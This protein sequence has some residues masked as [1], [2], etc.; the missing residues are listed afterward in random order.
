MYGD[1]KTE[2]ISLPKAVSSSFLLANTYQKQAKKTAI[3]PEQ[4][5]LAYTIL[6]LTN[7]AGEVAGKYKKFLRDGTQFIDLR[8]KLI[9]ELGDVLWYAAMLSEEIGTTLGEVMERNLGKL[10]DRANRGTLGG[11]GD[12]R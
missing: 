4:H 8:E 10:E 9:D 5:G 12:K 1:E 3:Y 2:T 7:E 11:S 6:G